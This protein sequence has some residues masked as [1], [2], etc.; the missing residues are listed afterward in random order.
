MLCARVSGGRSR[1]EVGGR[2]ERVVKPREEGDP[3]VQ[4]SR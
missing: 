3:E 4:L 1:G 2:G